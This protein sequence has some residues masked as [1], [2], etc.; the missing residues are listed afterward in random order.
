MHNKEIRLT[1]GIIAVCRTEN[2]LC[3]TGKTTL[4]EMRNLKTAITAVRIISN[5]IHPIR[6]FCVNARKL[7][8]QTITPKPLLIQTAEYFG[9]L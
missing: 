2:A 7:C 6:P 8:N 5:P 9:N 4:S 3:K 1:L